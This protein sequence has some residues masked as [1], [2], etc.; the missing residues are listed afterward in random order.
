[1][2]LFPSAVS[3]LGVLNDRILFELDISAYIVLGI[4]RISLD[5]MPFCSLLGRH[6]IVSLQHDDYTTKD[7]TFKPCKAIK[8]PHFKQWPCER[9]CDHLV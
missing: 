6:C 3:F 4:L 9:F 5:K 2:Y 8:K 1:L 7:E